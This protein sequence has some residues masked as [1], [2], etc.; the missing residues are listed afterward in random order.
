MIVQAS[1]L[2]FRLVPGAPSQHANTAHL[3]LLFENHCAQ[4]EHLI[5][6]V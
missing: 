2:S 5:I 1:S 3:L 6:P 4:G